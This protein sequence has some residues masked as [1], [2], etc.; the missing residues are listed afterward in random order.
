IS[1]QIMECVVA[2]GASVR[3]FRISERKK[4]KMEFVAELEISVGNNSH[5]DKVISA[6]K[7]IRE[8]TTVLRTN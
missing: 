6:L 1:N 7:K 8:V 2:Q 3:A 5:L 4:S